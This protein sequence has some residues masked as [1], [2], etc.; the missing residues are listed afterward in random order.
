MADGSKFTTDAAEF[1]VDAG[2]PL[3]EGYGDNHIVIMARDP[4][5]FFAYWEITHERAEQIRVAHGRDSWDRSALTLRVYD[6]GQSS[7]TPIE[8]TAFS[9]TDVDKFSRQW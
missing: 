8:N 5:C 2:A 7:Q 1:S 3:P 4:L 9:D 6:L